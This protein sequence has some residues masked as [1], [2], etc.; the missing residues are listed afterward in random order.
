VLPIVKGTR[1]HRYI[2]FH[3]SCEN[4]ESLLTKTDLIRAL[5]Q[6]TYVLFSKNAKEL[7]FWVVQFDGRNGILKCNYQEKEHS[8]Q[9]LQKLKTIGSKPVNITTHAT[10]G[11][12]HGLTN[13]KNKR[14]L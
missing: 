2:D 13:N 8:I 4:K 14:F 7:G 12:I 1:R 11:T 5:R 3:V 6:H 9:L 10:S